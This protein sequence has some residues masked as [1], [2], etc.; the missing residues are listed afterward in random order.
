MA[1]SRGIEP[2]LGLG[3]M[4]ITSRIVPLLLSIE[5]TLPSPVIFNE[6]T[7]PMAFSR[8]GS[9]HEQRTLLF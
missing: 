7:I 6:W 1:A 5:K 8:L 4:R 2:R 9:C 3:Y